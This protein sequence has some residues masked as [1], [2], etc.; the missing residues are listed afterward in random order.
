[1]SALSPSDP[2]PCFRPVSEITLRLVDWLWPGR[3]ALGEV[4]LLE[5]DPGLGKSFVALDLCARLSTGRPWPDGAPAPAP[6]ASVYLSGE[7]SDEATLGPR[8]RALGADLGRVFLPDRDAGPAATLCLPA[9]TDTLEQVVARTGAR[10]LVIDPVMHFLGREVNAASDP[11]VRRVLAPLGDMARRHGCAVLLVRHLNKTEGHKAIYRGLGSIAL[12][13]VSRS[14]WLVAEDQAAP[15]RRVLAQVKNNLGL[16]QPSLAFEVA[17][18]EGRAPTL[19]WLGP[20]AGTAEELVGA[21]RRHGPVPVKRKAAVAFLTELLSGG[22]VKVGDVWERVLKEG[23]SPKTVRNARDELGIRS[24][25]VREDGRNVTYWL[26]PGQRLPGEER[27]DPEMEE[28]DRH[29]EELNRM[30][31]PK[32]PLEDDDF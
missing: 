21:A 20:V 3:L 28:F 17:Q 5:G 26:L 8:L 9:Q 11:D 16:L 32:T 19:S 13:G 6:A 4:A 31:P 18:A 25:T 7:D 30:Y 23:R 24:R 29:L 14:A 15:A 10:L 27:R 22:P 1:M 2:P 12:G